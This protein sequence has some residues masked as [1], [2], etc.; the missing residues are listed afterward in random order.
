MCAGSSWGPKGG[1]VQAEST[2]YLTCPVSTKSGSHQSTM[3]LLLLSRNK[4]DSGQDPESRAACL[5]ACWRVFLV[6]PSFVALLGIALDVSVFSRHFL[7]YIFL[8]FP[9][10]S[11]PICQ[12][13]DCS[14]LQGQNDWLV[15]SLSRCPRNCGEPVC[16]GS[17]CFLTVNISL[18][19]G[20][21]FFWR[22]ENKNLGNPTR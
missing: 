9:P 17:P 18:P 22:Q 21:F 5:S 16:F 4:A 6:A 20:N 15:Y 13:E 12:E 8:S 19:C 14:W 11:F 7:P 1:R 10:W 3:L 2:V